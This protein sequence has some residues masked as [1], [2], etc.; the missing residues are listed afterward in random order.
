MV[1][2]KDL[3][4]TADLGLRVFIDGELKGSGSTSDWLRSI[5]QLLCELTDIV[6]L[7]PGDV[8]M[9]GTPAK[10]PSAAVG[11]EVRIEIDGLG[12]LKNTIALEKKSGGAS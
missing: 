7:C 5:P 12:V 11:Q 2:K 1:D 9:T 3:A 8:V 6:S 4:D 10:A